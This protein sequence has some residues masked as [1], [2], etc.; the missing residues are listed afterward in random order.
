MALTFLAVAVVGFAPSYWVPMVRGT[1][2][3][4]PIAHLHAPFFYGW[5]LLF[6]RQARLVAAGRV[7]RHRELGVVGVALGTGMCFVGL[8]VAINTLNRLDAAGL[9]ASG[10]PFAIV[11]VS[12]IALFA[13][14]FVVAVVN[15]RA[16]EVHRRVM[17]VATASLLQA[18]VGRWFLLF[19]APPRPPGFTGPVVPP[20]VAATIGAGLVVDLLIVAAMVHDS[21]AH[22]RVHRAYWI[23][24]AS[25]LA[26]QLLRVPISATDAWI[27]VTYWLQALSP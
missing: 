3:G 21:R 7:G 27:R 19:L 14:L 24:G 16:P 8:G 25:V 13:V 23:A 18:A 15:V 20:P 11:S 1:L 9:G 5:L 6:L 10:R 17:L 12:A 22:G 26:V 2:D 4:P